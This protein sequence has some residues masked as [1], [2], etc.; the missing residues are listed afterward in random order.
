MSELNLLEFFALFQTQVVKLHAQ[1]HQA[2]SAD[3]VLQAKV[4]MKLTP[5][6]V[7]SPPAGG[8]AYQVGVRLLCE[9]YKGEVQEA[10]PVHVF[11]IECILNAGYQQIQGTAVSFE[12]FSLHHASLTRQLYPLIH[13]QLLPLF[14]QL[15][16][17]GVRLPQE[18][19][20]TSASATPR[21]VH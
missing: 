9:G 18:I 1:L 8:T 3:D 2:I 12:T 15:G 11:S 14:S 6:K 5:A 16:I 20:Q 21:Q 19:I 7:A 17:P 10:D 13:H 4:E